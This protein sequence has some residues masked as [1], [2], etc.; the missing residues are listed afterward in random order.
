MIV[1]V[2]KQVHSCDECPNFARVKTP[3]RDDLS[4]NY[5]CRAAMKCIGNSD[6]MASRMKVKNKV[7]EICPFKEDEVNR[8]PKRVR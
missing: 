4:V 7:S 1:K 6:S 5:I 8:R 2:V 3:G